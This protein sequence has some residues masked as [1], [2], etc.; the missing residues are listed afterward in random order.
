MSSQKVFEAF[1]SFLVKS[2]LNDNPALPES[3]LKEI[4][5]T[6]EKTIHLDT[7]LSSIGLDSMTMT[8][9]VVK[10]E[11]QFKIDASS[12]SFFELYDVKDLV[13]QICT[14]LTTSDHHEN[15][16]C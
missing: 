5:S 10:M 15:L 11:E 3:T 7:P 12:V 8:W 13:N 1:K 4:E 9:I 14:L 2:H 6:I 16:T